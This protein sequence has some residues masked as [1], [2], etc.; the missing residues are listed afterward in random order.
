MISVKRKKKTQTKQN[1]VYY[2]AWSDRPDA[3][4]IGFTTN[5]LDR[6]KSFL[7]GSP[8]DLWLLALESVKSIEEEYKSMKEGKTPKE[9]RNAQKD[10][11]TVK[12]F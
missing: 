3:V 4:K 12:N 2:C 6:M 5:V 10:I 9:L 8:S 11:K 1:F 7:T